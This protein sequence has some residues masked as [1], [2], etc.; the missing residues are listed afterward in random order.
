MSYTIYE[1]KSNYLIQA[2]LPGLEP[3]SIEVFVEKGELILKGKRSRPEG[4]IL[5]QEIPKREVHKSFR[6]PAEIDRE[7]ITAAYSSGSLHVTLPKRATR[8]D[9]K[10]AS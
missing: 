6:L 2:D 8:I 4:T 10:V 7:G 3:E 1:S 9:I 5:V